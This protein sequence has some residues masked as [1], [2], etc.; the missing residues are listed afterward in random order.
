MINK[1][2]LAPFI[3][4]LGILGILIVLG[5]IMGASFSASVANISPGVWF[6]IGL[7]IIVIILLRRKK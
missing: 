5:L 7:F 1:K 2:G 4:I 6:I 3:I